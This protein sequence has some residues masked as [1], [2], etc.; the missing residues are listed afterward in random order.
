MLGSIEILNLS[1]MNTS[2][3]SGFSVS[4]LLGLGLA[5]QLLEGRSDLQIGVE[6]HA[7]GGGRPHDWFYEVKVCKLSVE[8]FHA[9]ID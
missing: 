7:T 1:P 2:V 8:K 9:F 6:R 5:F 4:C 3:G